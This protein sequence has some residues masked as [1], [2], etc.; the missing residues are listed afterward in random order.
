MTEQTV[1]EVIASALELARQT[2][3]MEAAHFG[4]FT[5]GCQIIEQISGAASE[6]GLE[7]GRRV[8]IQETICRLM[9]AGEVPEIIPDAAG[10]SALAGVPAVAARSI[11]AYVGVPVS[12]SDGTAFGSF[13]CLSAHADPRLKDRDITFM[14][15]LGRLVG[16]SRAPPEPMRPSAS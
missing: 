6:F 12:A 14:R 16:T 9:V 15:L 10:V 8:P 1:D 2:L 3:G 13:C 5:A 7:R 11:G 4:S